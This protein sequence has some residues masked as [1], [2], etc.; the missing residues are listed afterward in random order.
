MGYLSLTLVNDRDTESTRLGES[1]K[2]N[3]VLVDYTYICNYSSLVTPCGNP[4][5]SVSFERTQWI[6]T[7]YRPKYHEYDF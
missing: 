5:V 6:Y 3:L 4:S 7:S 2:K 1:L